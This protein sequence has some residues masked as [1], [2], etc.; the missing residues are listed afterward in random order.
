MRKLTQF[1]NK[2]LRIIQN[3]P[4]IL[5]QDFA[6]KMWPES[7]MHIRSHNGGHGSQRGKGA[8]LCAGSHIGKLIK[9][10]LI[11]QPLV[12]GHL[13]GYKLT[14]KGREALKKGGY[15]ESF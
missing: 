2:A 13:S 5:A 7:S 11:F 8:W 1:Q 3:T 15:N 9:K 12:N 14:R 10:G 6:T 4:G